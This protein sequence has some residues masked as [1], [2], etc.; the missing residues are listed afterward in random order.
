METKTVVGDVTNVSD[1]DVMTRVD[2]KADRLIANSTYA[3]EVKNAP[4]AVKIIVQD[5]REEVQ[6]RDNLDAQSA[7]KT[8]N[9]AKMHAKLVD[10][11]NN[12]WV[13][14]IQ[15]QCGN[16]PEKV[17]A[18]NFRYKGSIEHTPPTTG[19][20]PMCTGIDRNVPGEHTMHIIDTLANK[21][22]L[23]WG[24]LRCDVYGQCDGV[25]PTTLAELTA[26]GGGWLGTVDNGK[27]TY[28][29]PAGGK[30]KTEYYI[31]VYILKETKKPFAYSLVYSAIIS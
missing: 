16:D 25:A 29:T 9:I 21:A 5:M 4:A 3:S 14:T 10:I 23:P 22:A 30:G 20:I 7:A 2:L 18:L 12:D 27:F 8:A 15:R 28:V 19:N 17:T 11:V 1:A 26:H 6:S 24:I 31:F 13:P